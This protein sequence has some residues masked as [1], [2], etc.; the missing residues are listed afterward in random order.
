M[1]S[2]F[3]TILVHNLNELNLNVAKLKKKTMKKRELIFPREFRIQKYSIDVP[4]LL[5][6][7][8]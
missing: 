8:R 5:W 1:T 3:T 7:N 2:Y 6:V 4:L